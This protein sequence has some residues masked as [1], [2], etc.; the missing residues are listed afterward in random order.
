MCVDYV[1][2]TAG[3]K[4]L[5]KLSFGNGVQLCDLSCQCVASSKQGHILYSLSCR[6][7]F[8]PIS[9]SKEACGAT[10]KE[11]LI[12]RLWECLQLY[13]PVGPVSS[14]LSGGFR[15]VCEESVKL[16]ADFP[17]KK[18]TMAIQ[19]LHYTHT[20]GTKSLIYQAVRCAYAPVCIMRKLKKKST[21]R[22][23]KARNCARNKSVKYGSLRRPSNKEK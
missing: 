9:E 7:S 13:R 4:N 1:K 16:G 19:R 20:R 5:L 3:V 6:N 17:S 2:Q 8:R 12:R 15:C 11:T 22:T 18:P 14:D 21:V 10:A 23:G